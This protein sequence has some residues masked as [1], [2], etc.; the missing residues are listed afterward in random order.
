MFKEEL[1][2]EDS[3]SRINTIHKVP[4]VATL[5]PV[6]GIKTTLLPFLETLCKKEDDEVVFAITEE[7]ANLA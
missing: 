3:A 6:E 2:T 1:D 5:M 4:I 7:Y